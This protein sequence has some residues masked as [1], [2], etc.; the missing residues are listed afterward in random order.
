MR[1]TLPIRVS[2][3]VTSDSDV[4]L[5]RNQQFPLL[6]C[7]WFHPSCRSPYITSTHT[8]LYTAP[9][10]QN[11]VGNKFINSH[12][13]DTTTFSQMYLNSDRL[14]QLLFK[15]KLTIWLPTG[16]SLWRSKSFSWDD[17]STFVSL[18][19]TN[20]SPHSLSETPNRTCWNTYWYWKQIE[21][22]FIPGPTD[23]GTEFNI[24]SSFFYIYFSFHAS[25]VYNI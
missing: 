15:K 5:C 9:T 12:T 16:R 18:V 2:S 10:E 19:A 24:T 3:S 22:Q 1:T 13:Q 4:A 20:Y 17:H 23:G 6:H 8:N 7:H 11:A 21:C 25:Q 14:Y